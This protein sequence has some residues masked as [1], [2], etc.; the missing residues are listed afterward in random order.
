MVERSEGAGN[1]Q[2]GSFEYTRV[3]EGDKNL[4]SAFD[5]ALKAATYWTQEDYQ[6]EQGDFATLNV[7]VVVLSLP[8]WDVCIDPHESGAVPDPELRTRAF[9]VGLYPG[10]PQAREV[11]TGVW[12]ASE[13]D[14]LV[15]ALTGLFDWFT[16]AIGEGP[17]APFSSLVDIPVRPRP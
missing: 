2:S 13:L 6:I 1:K 16:V 15:G 17:L 14:T 4:F 12:I 3:K 8:F 11:L 5:S 9:Q 7:P 10:R